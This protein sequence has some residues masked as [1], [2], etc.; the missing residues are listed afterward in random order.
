MSSVVYVLRSPAE[1]MSSALYMA[2]VQ[3]AVVIRIDQVRP[4][5]SSQQVGQI[6][7]P[8]SVNALAAG[9]AVTASQLLDLLMNA[10]KVLTL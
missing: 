2:A 10:Q 6:V 8:G 9:Q 7:S 4:G 1:K 5:S 3:E